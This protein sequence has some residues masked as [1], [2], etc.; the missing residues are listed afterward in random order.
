MVSQWRASHASWAKPSSL[1]H[2]WKRQAVETGSESE[3]EVL[4]FKK[5]VR[6][7]EMG[8]DILKVSIAG[9]PQWN[10]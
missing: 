9:S 5:R 7:L 3:R 1:L 6:E 10:P 2:N 4:A 8:R